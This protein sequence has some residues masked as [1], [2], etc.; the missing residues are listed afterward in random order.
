MWAWWVLVAA[1][2]FLVLVI[3]TWDID[4]RRQERRRRE[5]R[6]ELKERRKYRKY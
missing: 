4:N 5:R 3:A 6:E 1:I 2:A